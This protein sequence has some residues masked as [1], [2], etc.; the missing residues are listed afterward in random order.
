MSLPH[1]TPFP[2]ATFDNDAPPLKPVEF[3]AYMEHLLL[4]R[5]EGEGEEHNALWINVLV[6]LT[7]QFFAAF[8]SVSEVNSW[9]GMHEKVRLAAGTLE[10]IRRVSDRLKE[11]L[12][13]PR[14]L[15][16]RTFAR[17]LN[18]CHVLEMWFDIEFEQMEGLPSP[19]ELAE[20][21]FQTAVYLLRSF[22]GAVVHVA[23]TKVPQWKT[24]RAI[25]SECLDVLEGKSDSSCCAL[26][27]DA[28]T[29]ISPQDPLHWSSLWRL[30]SSPKPRSK[31]RL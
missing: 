25:L 15:A 26:H 11:I 29:Q 9:H 13:G 31:T 8:P 5:L 3:L 2:V 28:R 12:L 30:P 7:E 22:G 10:V 20:D 23:D 18:F 19:R 16:R 17:L 21:A 6:G 27:T 1:A 14:D 4:T 24:L